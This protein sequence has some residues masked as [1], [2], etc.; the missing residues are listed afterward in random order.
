MTDNTKDL[1]DGEKLNLILAK[2]SD[3]EARLAK[4]EAQENNNRPRAD[5]DSHS[6]VWLDYSDPAEMIC[7]PQD[8]FRIRDGLLL[9]YI[10]PRL[11]SATRAQRQRF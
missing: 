5:S 2:L 9:R 6:D 1:P 7:C 8:Y 11:G 10:C 4:L 3:M